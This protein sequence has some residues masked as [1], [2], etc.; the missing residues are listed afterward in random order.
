MDFSENSIEGIMSRLDT[1][2]T[3]AKDID[4]QITAIERSKNKQQFSSF[5][6]NFADPEIPESPK[7]SSMQSSPKKSTNF[8]SSAEEIK[9]KPD[10]KP[11]VSFATEYDQSEY[12]NDFLVEVLNSIK[13][14]RTQVAEIA[15]TQIQMKE[16]V[17]SLKRKRN[18]I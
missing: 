18:I 6:Q 16:D 9:E 17:K 14:L 3:R 7:F 13:E 15:E 11:Q 2:L 1:I 5:K 4:T 12:S 10:F 8:Y